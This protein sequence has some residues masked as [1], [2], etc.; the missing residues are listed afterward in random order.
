MSKVSQIRH[1]RIRTDNVSGD[2]LWLHW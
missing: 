2:R 1:A